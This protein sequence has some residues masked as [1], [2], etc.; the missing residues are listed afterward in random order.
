M[1]S[2]A[3]QLREIRPS[4]P[5]GPLAGRSPDQARALLSAIRQGW[6]SGLSEGGAGTDGQGAAGVGEQ[7][8]W[9]WQDRA[10]GRAEELP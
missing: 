8:Q 7:G 6:R 5:L 3:P 1:S 9:T 4:T 2:M 10:E